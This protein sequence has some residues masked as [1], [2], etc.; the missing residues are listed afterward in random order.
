MP[1]CPLT[2]SVPVPHQTERVKLAALAVLLLLQI[3]YFA[4]LLRS[5]S[6][7]PGTDAY[8]YA[9]Q[10]RSLLDVGHLK[11]PDGGVLYYAMAAVVRTGASIETSFRICLSAIYTLY[12]LGILL[13]I[14]RL[15]HAIWF[16]AVL[17][18]VITIPVIAFHVVEFP[19]LSLGLA[20]IPFWFYFLG[21]ATVRSMFWL[22][23]LLAG[24]S[25]LHVMVFVLAVLF[26][27]AV[28]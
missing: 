20:M 12:G 19:N 3:A 9:L 15:K 17:L 22:T 7:L 14:V 2:I 21:C 23:L 27:A 16:L 1:C 26:T 24:S 6:Y 5:F 18:W 10:T 4:Y 28:G 13:L 11:V 25:L 8:Y